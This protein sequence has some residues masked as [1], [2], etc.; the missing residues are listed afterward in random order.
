MLVGKLLDRVD[1][2]EVRPQLDIVTRSR[3]LRVFFQF[4]ALRDPVH[5]RPAT[6]A[7]VL[8]TKLLNAVI[9]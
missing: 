7:S 4:L 2:V 8:L 3:L 1:P 5:L 9:D 6:T